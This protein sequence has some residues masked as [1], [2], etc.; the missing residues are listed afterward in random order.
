[1]STIQ[2]AASFKVVRALSDRGLAMQLPIIGRRIM[3]TDFGINPNDETDFTDMYM[4]PGLVF[5]ATRPTID[6]PPAEVQKLTAAFY[7]QITETDFRPTNSQGWTRR[8]DY[9]L[10]VRFK[11]QDLYSGDTIPEKELHQ[12]VG[13]PTELPLVGYVSLNGLTPGG[14]P[15]MG[16]TIHPS[17][18]GRGLATE[19]LAL[20]AYPLMATGESNIYATRHPDNT[21]AEK[22]QNR[23]G[24]VD[25]G[26][27]TVQLLTGETEPRI[28]S[29]M[30]P[31]TY[32]RAPEWAKLEPFTRKG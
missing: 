3:L 30:R 19:M 11:H 25:T 16:T 27:T 29:E 24:F 21:G 8:T 1:M 6:T 12:A 10:A 22:S 9:R 26:E 14:Q 23:S 32:F 31:D 17:F 5:W 13:D 20:L 28:T 2:P 7:R 4:Q 15:D 18:Q